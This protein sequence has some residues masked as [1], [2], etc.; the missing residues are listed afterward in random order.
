MWKCCSVHNHIQRTIHVWRKFRHHFTKT[1]AIQGLPSC[2]NSGF[3]DAGR[4]ASKLV[5]DGALARLVWRAE[6]EVLRYCKW[7]WS[8]RISGGN[9]D[10][11]RPDMNS[12][13]RWLGLAGCTCWIGVPGLE[14]L[15][16]P[17]NK[18]PDWGVMGWC[19]DCG[20][21]GLFDSGVR[22]AKFESPEPA[23]LG[24][25]KLLEYMDPSPDALEWGPDQNINATTS[26]ANY[27]KNTTQACKSM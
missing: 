16:W 17:G 2:S 24:W 27:L 10:D 15:C 21:K 14:T 1:T 9:V 25:A 13:S 20:V 23:G 11:P 26:T 6:V 12:L 4:S 18:C 5:S 3:I 8:S 7:D 19:P 22:G